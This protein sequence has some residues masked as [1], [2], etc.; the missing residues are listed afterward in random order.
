MNRLCLSWLK[1]FDSQALNQLY[2]STITSSVKFTN[3]TQP[4]VFLDFE[5]KFYLQKI[6]VHV[7]FNHV[8]LTF[9]VQL[10]MDLL[11]TDNMS[12]DNNPKKK[13]KK[14]FFAD[15]DNFN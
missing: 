8:C 11:F 4:V 1:D 13:K 9:K 14:V 2:E 3:F 10:T 12:N 5:N 7:C 15:L 6:L